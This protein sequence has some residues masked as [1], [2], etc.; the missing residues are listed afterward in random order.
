MEDNGNG[1]KDH[2]IHQL[3]VPQE[4]QKILRIPLIDRAQDDTLTWD[5]TLD[6]NYTVKT[7]Y[8][9]IKDWEEHSSSN[10][11]SSSGTPNDIW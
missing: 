3:F 8:T 9:A 1:W 5:G 11:A 10:I 4:A 7:G 6:G 2:L